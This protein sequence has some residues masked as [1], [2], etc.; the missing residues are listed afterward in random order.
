MPVATAPSHCHAP[1]RPDLRTEKASQCSARFFSYYAPL[2]GSVL[3]RFL[4]ARFVSGLLELGFPM[5]VKLFVDK[6]LPRSNWTLIVAASAGLL[7]IY[8]FNTG[9]MAVVTYWGHMLGINI[10]TEMR[11]QELRPPAEALVPLLR[12]PQDRPSCRP[13]HQGPRGDRR[14][15]ASRPRGP[16]HRRDD[17]LRRLRADVRGQCR[18]L[19]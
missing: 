13:R 8:V 11:R 3:A 9:L 6:L 7:A 1:G 18:S 14:G 12:Q 2:E 19:R 5:A 17:L 15:R 4:P 16:V 10:E